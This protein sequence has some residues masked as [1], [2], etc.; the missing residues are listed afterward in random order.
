MK[1]SIIYF[2]T[3]FLI[4]T[5][6][7]ILQ[8]TLSDAF[9]LAPPEPPEP[10]DQGEGGPPVGGGAPVGGGLIFLM[11]IS[12]VYGVKKMLHTIKEK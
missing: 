10:P 4:I 12:A 5:I 7:I 6:M 1:K 9:A 3:V 8:A 2:V 11:F